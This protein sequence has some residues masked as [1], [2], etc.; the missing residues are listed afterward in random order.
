MFVTLPKKRGVYIMK[1]SQSWVL[2]QESSF[3]VLRFHGKKAAVLSS[4]TPIPISWG[5]KLPLAVPAVSNLFP[6]TVQ[7]EKEAVEVAT[8]AQGGGDNLCEEDQE[9]HDNENIEEVVCFPTSKKTNP[10]QK[11]S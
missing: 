6:P 5:V 4:T 2:Q 9:S 7:V 3:L 8:D 11:T 1:G 10:N